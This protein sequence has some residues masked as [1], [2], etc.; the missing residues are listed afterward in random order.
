MIEIP[1]SDLNASHLP[2]LATQPI[3]IVVA[4]LFM[5][6]TRIGTIFLSALPPVLAMTTNGSPAARQVQARQDQL[7]QTERLGAVLRSQTKK[8]SEQVGKIGTNLNSL[9]QS[10]AQ[11]QPANSAKRSTT[12]S[13]P[14]AMPLHG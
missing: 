8:L 7:V 3:G 12:R 10:F 13:L 11:G 2:T 1:L 14:I 5:I 4:T 6:I 9:R